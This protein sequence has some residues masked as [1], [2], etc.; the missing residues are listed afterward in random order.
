MK[1]FKTTRTDLSPDGA[2]GKI[3]KKII[4]SQHRIAD[5]LNQR[6][7]M[8]SRK[9]SIVALAA[10]CVVSASYLIWLLINALN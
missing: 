6:T 5:Y 2:A 9:S 1:L 7:K 3:A 4:G 8:V 10:F